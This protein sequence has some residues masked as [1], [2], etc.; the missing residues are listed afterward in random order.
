MNCMKQM[1]KLMPVTPDTEDINECIRKED[2]YRGS[3]R[4]AIDIA[5]SHIVFPEPP[6]KPQIPVHLSLIHI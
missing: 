1:Y 3:I 6:V 2:E 5:N 4:I